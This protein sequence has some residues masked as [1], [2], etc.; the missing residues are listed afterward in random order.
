[1]AQTTPTLDG[2]WLSSQLRK[3]GKVSTDKRIRQKEVTFVVKIN[4][5]IGRFNIE[6]AKLRRNLLQIPSF[7]QVNCDQ[8]THVSG[9]YCSIF[10]RVV[11]FNGNDNI[12]TSLINIFFSIS[13]A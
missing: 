5:N 12:E 4:W 11:K 1:M 7:I 3:L 8:F 9:K 6:G 2:Q 10:G 13:F